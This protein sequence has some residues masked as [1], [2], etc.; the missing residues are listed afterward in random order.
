VLV[1]LG[2]VMFTGAIFLLDRKVVKEFLEFTQAAF[3]RQRK[4]PEVP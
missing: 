2:A 4:N 1:P 3:Q